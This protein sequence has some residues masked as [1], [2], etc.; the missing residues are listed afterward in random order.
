MKPLVLTEIA[1]FAF[2]YVRN[3]PATLLK[4]N[5]MPARLNQVLF[6]TKCYKQSL[7]LHVESKEM[8]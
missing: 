2:I 6:S 4:H 5:T 7:I 3:A 8:S 1:T